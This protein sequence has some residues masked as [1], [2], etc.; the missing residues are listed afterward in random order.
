MATGA[1]SVHAPTY[2]P[3]GWTLALEAD[4]EETL[5]F[6]SDGHALL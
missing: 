5:G 1:R 4:G 3:S 6:G 2:V